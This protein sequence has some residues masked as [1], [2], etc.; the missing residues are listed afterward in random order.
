MRPLSSARA[1][2]SWLLITF[3]LCHRGRLLVV[4]LEKCSRMAFWDRRFQLEHNDPI[5]YVHLFWF[6]GHPEVYVLVMPPMAFL[7]RL[8]ADANHKG[9]YHRSSQIMAI[10]LIGILGYAVYGHHLF[11]MGLSVAYSC[12]TLLV[13]LPT[14]QKM[15][16]LQGEWACPTPITWYPCGWRA[17]WWPSHCGLGGHQ[18]P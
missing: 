7:S 5:L 15:L 11:T 4:M 9:V 3:I 16:T 17:S 6:S 8:V 13:A 2:G 18:L 12:M 10:Q 1:Y 14:G